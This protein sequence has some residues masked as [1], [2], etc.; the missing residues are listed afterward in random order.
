[1]KRNREPWGTTCERCSAGVVMFGDTP[2]VPTTVRPQ[3]TAF[4]AG[5][6]VLHYDVCPKGAGLR[7]RHKGPKKPQRKGG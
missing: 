5:V 6:H 1:M 3:D 2:V 7:R 4:V